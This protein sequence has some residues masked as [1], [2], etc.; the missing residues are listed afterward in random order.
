MYLAITSRPDIDY[1]VGFL[2][3]FNS[4]PCLAHWEAVKHLLHYLKGTADYGII[5]A[6]NP[7]STE[8]FSTFPD[9]DH[10][11][12]KDTGCSTS[13]YLVKIGSGAVSW[14]SK[15]QSIVAL[16][17]TEAEYIAAVS[18]GKEIRWMRNLL[19]EMGFPP[20][21]PSILRIDNQ[22][23]ISVAKHPEHHG[24]MKLLSSVTSMT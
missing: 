2:A 3:R 19:Q 21:G 20:T 24:R 8:L 12:C 10:G 14:S 1:T 6:P 13:G 5:Y 4:K 23:A 17:T 11:G 16:S 7:H 9:T 18:A 22:S 15:L